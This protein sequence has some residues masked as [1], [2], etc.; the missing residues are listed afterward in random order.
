MPTSHHLRYAVQNETLC[1]T[2]RLLIAQRDFAEESCEF[3]DAWWNTTL[4]FL[5]NQAYMMTAYD[6]SPPYKPWVWNPYQ[7]A[8]EHKKNLLPIMLA[9]FSLSAF[10]DNVFG[11]LAATPPCDTSNLEAKATHCIMEYL[12]TMP[13]VHSGLDILPALCKSIRVKHLNTCWRPVAQACPGVNATQFYNTILAINDNLCF[14]ANQTF[15]HEALL[16]EIVALLQNRSVT[17][18]YWVFG[19]NYLNAY[20]WSNIFLFD[21]KEIW[22][23]MSYLLDGLMQAMP[24]S[25]KYHHQLAV[26]NADLKQAMPFLVGQKYDRTLGAN[27]WIEHV[28]HFF[29][30]FIYELMPAV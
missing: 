5:I 14:I 15:A 27:F 6:V 21:K 4:T 7:C 11:V 1:S 3:V 22:Q 12:I 20:L 13:L 29:I 28:Q 24:T 26:L 25:Y 17:I 10:S 23:V 9:S 16:K 8:H 19:R 2:L 30:A 18:N